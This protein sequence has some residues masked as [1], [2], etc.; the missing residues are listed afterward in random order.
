MRFS[1]KHYW[2][3]GASEGLGLALAAQMRA[4]GAR[5]TLS[6]R[7]ETALAAAARALPG[8]AV[9]PMDVSDNAAVQRAA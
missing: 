3:V 9:V 2:L 8:V 4:Q 6:A 1:G 7:S 5:L